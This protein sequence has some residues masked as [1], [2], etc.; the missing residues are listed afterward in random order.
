M[1]ALLLIQSAG[2][3]VPGGATEQANKDNANDEINL[4][5]SLAGIIKA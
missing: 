5:G 2:Q 4:C 1:S 3:A